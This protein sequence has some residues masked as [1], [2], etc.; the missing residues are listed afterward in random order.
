[1]KIILKKESEFSFGGKGMQKNA[2]ILIAGIFVMLVCI[3][4]AG[5]ASVTPVTIDGNP[6]CGEVNYIGFKVE[7]S[8]FDVPTVT[9]TYYLDGT[10]YVTIET[11]CVNSGLMKI[12]CGSEYDPNAFDWTSNFPVDAV[13]VKGGPNANMYVY[14]PASTGD[15]LLTP[16]INDLTETPY[17]L[18]HVEFCYIF[19]APEFPVWFISC[20]GIAML[21]GLVFAFRRK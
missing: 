15:T 9:G 11:Y 20:A 8:D 4:I 2:G 6:K 16:P 17:G 12:D 21:L 7:S 5:A 1:V 19:S 18:S 13:I 14:D 3:G 10:H